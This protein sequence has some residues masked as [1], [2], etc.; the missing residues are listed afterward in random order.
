MQIEGT[1]TRPTLRFRCELFDVYLRE[2]TLDSAEFHA[3]GEIENMRTR[4]YLV[5]VARF[6]VFRDFRKN[7]PSAI[8]DVKLLSRSSLPIE[9]R[10]IQQCVSTTL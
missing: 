1:Q 7:V 10:T 4:A 5:S 2:D 3:T 6:T 8:A 9:N